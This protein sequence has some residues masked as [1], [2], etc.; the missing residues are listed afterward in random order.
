M[1]SYRT[2]AA[3]Y[4]GFDKGELSPRANKI[5]ITDEGVSVTKKDESSEDGEHVEVFS[6]SLEDFAAQSA[7]LAGLPRLHHA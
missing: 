2:V 6:M 4:K 3:L 5:L 7:K 1:K